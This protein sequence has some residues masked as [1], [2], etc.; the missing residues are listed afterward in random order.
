MVLL[1][2]QDDSYFQEKYVGNITNLV[3]PTTPDDTTLQDISQNNQFGN[4][5][6]AFYT[7]WFFMYGVWDPAVNGDAGDNVMIMI[8]A[9]LFTFLTVLIFFNLT[10]ARMSGAVEKVTK[11]GDKIWITHFAAVLS[12]IELLWYSERR[13]QSKQNNPEFVFYNANVVSIQKHGLKLREETDKLK[14]AI[15]SNQEFVKDF[16]AE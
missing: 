5:L 2:D 15:E 13:R 9:F 16:G 1:Y 8:L 7:V 10:I 6:K 14:D 4:P 11:L 12:E 3:S